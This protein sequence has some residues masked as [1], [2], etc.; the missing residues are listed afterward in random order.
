MLVIPKGTEHVR[1]Q[2]AVKDNDYSSYQIVLRAVAGPEI[3]KGQNLK[4][5]IAKSGAVFSLSVAPSKLATGDY[6]LTL[7]GALQNGELEDVSKSL[8]RIE[9]K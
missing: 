4:P 9:K 7:R 5:R 3:F 6:M 8:F 1:V 2:L